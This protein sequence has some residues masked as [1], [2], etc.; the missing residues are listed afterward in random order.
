MLA[1]ETQTIADMVRESPLRANVFERYQIDYCC[2]G[3]RW[4]VKS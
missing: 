3:K 1:A 4:R 2:K